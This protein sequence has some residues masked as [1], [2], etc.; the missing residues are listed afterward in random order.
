[1]IERMNLAAAGAGIEGAE[2]YILKNDTEERPADSDPRAAASSGIQAESRREDLFHK[3]TVPVTKWAEERFREGS[4]LIFV[5]SIGIAV[6]AIAGVVQD[7]LSDSPVIVIDDLG[8]F[9]I[10][11][12]SGHAGGANQMAAMIAKLIGAIPVITTSTD[13]HGAFSADVFARENRLTIRSREGIR[14]VSAKA[15]EGKPVVIS[16]KNYPPEEPVDIIVA[17]E[18]DREYSLLLVPK[19]F[20]LGAGMRRDTDPS[21]A[22]AFFLDILGK[23]GIR[24]DDIYAVSTIDIKQNE[25]ALR[26]FCD[27][28]RL[29][30]I[31]FDAEM[32]AKARGNF[33]SSKFVQK[34]VGVDNVCERAAVLCAGRSAE[35]VVTKQTGSGITC[36][37]ARRKG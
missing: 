35:L 15:I 23:N 20:V 31:T 1:M 14:N 3:V 25:P 27:R 33:S 17:D 34:T 16:V 12:L 21:A 28:Y 7:K 4:A 10:P 13:I 22:E 2:A 36:A 29:P 19:P 24:T 26:A 9:V 8:Q 5:G 18:T 30:L 37:V 11:I 32:L 6:R